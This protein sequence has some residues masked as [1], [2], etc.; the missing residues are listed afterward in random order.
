[1]KLKAL[2]ALWI[3]IG[4][5]VTISNAADNVSAAPDKSAIKDKNEIKQ[6]S[7]KAK[8]GKKRELMLGYM[9]YKYPEEMEKLSVL[10]KTDPKAARKKFQA[11]SEQARKEIKEESEKFKAMVQEYHKTKDEKLLEQIKTKMVE[12]RNIRIQATEKI[13]GTLEN[14]LKELEK[15]Q[16]KAADELKDAKARYEE[17]KAN[18]EDINQNLKEITKDPKFNY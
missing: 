2:C 18:N 7:N 16:Q 4:L 9:L 13:I 17:L 1:M 8:W 15:R 10:E 3:I 5:V 6:K 14:N 11:L 12:T